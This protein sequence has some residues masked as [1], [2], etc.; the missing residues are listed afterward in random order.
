[1]VF[2]CI[3]IPFGPDLKDR[4]GSEAAS[5]YKVNWAKEQENKEWQGNDVPSMGKKLETKMRGK[6]R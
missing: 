5:R 4:Q 2:Y 6:C 3:P 1:M